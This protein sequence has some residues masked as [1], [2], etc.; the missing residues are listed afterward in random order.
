MAT[1]VT[2][3]DALEILGA[4]QNYD[5]FQISIQCPMVNFI[6]LPVGVGMSHQHP[7]T[8][9]FKIHIS[10][11]QAIAAVK[12]YLTQEMEDLGARIPLSMKIGQNSKITYCVG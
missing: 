3:A 2:R 11:N 7:F 12:N 10:R 5:A 1:Y 9:S 8:S 4:A 6:G